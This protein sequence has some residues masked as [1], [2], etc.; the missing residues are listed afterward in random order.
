VLYA[1]ERLMAEGLLKATRQGTV[2]VYPGLTNTM[3]ARP[4]AFARTLSRRTDGLATAADAAGA[5]PAAFRPGLP[6][7][8]AFPL[9]QWRTALARAWQRA[10]WTALDYAD[11]RGYSGLRRAIAEYVRISRNVCCNAEQVFITEGTQSSLDHVARLLADAG[12][13]A[14][15]ENP[16]YRGARAAFQAAGLKLVPI[17]VDLHGIAPTAAHWRA[18]P[19]RLVYITP[20]HQYP[21]GG[22]LSMDRR[23]ALIDMARRHDAWIVEDDYDSEFRHEGAPLSAVQGLA[24]DAPVLYLGTFSKTLFPALR[25][26]FLIVPPQIVDAVAQVLGALAPQGRVMDQ[27]ALADFIE[28]GQYSLHLRRMRKLYAERRA[29]LFDALER[30]LRGAMTV[31]GGAGG[32]HLSARLDVPVADT[33][34]AARAW[35]KELAIRPL[36]LYCLDHAEAQRYNGLALGYA[37]VPVEQMDAS[38]VRLAQ[39]VEE[40]LSRFPG[41][42]V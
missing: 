11:S 34:V 7:L 15:I 35:E 42:Q 29:A 33:V 30:R 16:G 21:L 12:D 6:A 10:D 13:I 3:P 27:M 28:S 8:D 4:D 22:V 39:A 38:V 37:G 40:A 24:P 36:S 26:G 1:Y 2:A 9:G 25:L 14:W 31:S 20:S 5:Q 18:T 32:M 19:P 17:P 41:R 23:V